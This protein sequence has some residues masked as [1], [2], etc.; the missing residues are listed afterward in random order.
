MTPAELRFRLNNWQT[1]RRVRRLRA[2]HR[3]DWLTLAGVGLALLGLWWLLWF[4]DTLPPA[5]PLPPL[6]VWP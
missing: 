4:V 6:D 5:S 2:E 3:L 1:I